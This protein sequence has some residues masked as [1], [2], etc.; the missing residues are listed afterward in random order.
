[1]LLLLITRV[2]LDAQCVNFRER[3]DDAASCAVS[4]LGAD[5]DA[6]LVIRIRLE[7]CAMAG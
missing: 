2:V 1:M 4:A 5:A 6:Q 7:N 3:T